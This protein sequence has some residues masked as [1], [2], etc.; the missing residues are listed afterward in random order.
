MTKT[1]TEKTEKKEDPKK[2][3]DLSIDE[4]KIAAFDINGIIQN[5]TLLLNEVIARIQEL[6]NEA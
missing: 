3:N 1:P 6:E 5:N 2:V 4:L